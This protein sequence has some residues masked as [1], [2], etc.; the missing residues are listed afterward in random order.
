[1]DLP[2]IAEQGHPGVALEKL[3]GAL[4]EL[5]GK[6]MIRLADERPGR[7]TLTAKR[8][9]TLIEL[10]VVIAIIAIL[11]AILLPVFASARERARQSSCANNLRQIGLAIMQYTQDFDEILPYGYDYP[12]DNPYPGNRSIPPTCT[13]V[14]N[15]C[16][17][18][19]PP[20]QMWMDVIFPYVKSKAVYFCPSGPPDPFPN[21]KSGTYCGLPTTDP[22]NTFGY[23]SNTNVLTQWIRLYPAYVD[24]NCHGSNMPTLGLSKVVSSSGTIMLAD[25]GFIDRNM[26][27]WPGSG[28]WYDPTDP[29]A[30]SYGTNPSWRHNGSSNFL[31]VDGHVKPYS[32]AQFVLFAANAMNPA[33]GM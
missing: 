16:A 6:P 31:F 19:D 1:M 33:V 26:L 5:R 9:F 25:R 20:V 11:A 7:S 4:M 21:W 14:Q 24:A 12:A 22:A 17:F 3:P 30:K 15:W 28:T 18:D 23:A 2:R 32:L 13:T 27:F 29:T 10:L 8:G